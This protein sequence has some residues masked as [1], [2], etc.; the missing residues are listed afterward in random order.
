MSEART[1]HVA[2]LC[3]SRPRYLYCSKELVQMK[4]EEMKRLKEKKVLL[5]QQLERS[6]ARSPRAVQDPAGRW[7]FVPLHHLGFPFP[8]SLLKPS[9]SQLRSFVLCCSSVVPQVSP[10]SHV[11]SCDVL[12]FSVGT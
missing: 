1:S 4:R 3:N 9:P 8:A 6:V 10:N 11:P 2:G 7:R 5:E 12:C